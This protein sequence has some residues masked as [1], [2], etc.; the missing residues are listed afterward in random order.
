[1][2]KFYSF[3]Y[4]Q[5]P[6]LPISRQTRTTTPLAGSAAWTSATFASDAFSICEGSVFTDKAG[7]L[8]IEQSNDDLN[9]DISSNYIIPVSDGKGFTEDLLLPFTRV[10]YVNGG[11]PQTIFRLYFNFI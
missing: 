1:M 10:R 8:F 9:W 7:T 2:P 6:G 3:L 5:A 11:T 4:P